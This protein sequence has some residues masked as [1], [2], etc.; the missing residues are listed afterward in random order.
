MPLMKRPT[1]HFYIILLPVLFAGLL[2]FNQ[3]FSYIIWASPQEA[4]QSWTSST[5]LPSATAGRNVIEHDGYLFFIGGDTNDSITRYVRVAHISSDGSLGTWRTTTSLPVPLMLHAVAQT[6]DYVYVIG[7][8]D[9]T[10]QRRRDVWRAGFLNNGQ[11]GSWDK[12]GEYPFV[13][14][15]HDAVV[16]DSRLYVVGGQSDSNKV[17]KDVYMADIKANGQLGSWR[18][19]RDIPIALSRHAITA[20]LP[21]GGCRTSDRI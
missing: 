18:K 15:Q 5:S 14:M 13:V 19:M 16:I 6:N 9:Y 12:V 3:L 7:G 17:K 1:I 8:F 11:L 4:I 10:R 2:S 21:A 20:L